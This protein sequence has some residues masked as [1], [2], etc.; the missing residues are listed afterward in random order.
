MT[1][2]L[3]PYLSFK[4][5]ARD[6]MSFYADV[7]GGE[8]T[9]STFGE[10]QASQDPAEHNL[11]MHSQLEAPNGMTLMA[12]DTPSSMEHQ[13]G[14]SISISLSGDDEAELRGYFERLSDGAEVFMPLDK[15]PWG[16]FFGMLTDRF[17]VRWMVNIAGGAGG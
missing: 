14:S 6:A 3:N 13:P 7:F 15:A 5:S 9:I 11:V 12:S 16:D 10:M 17:G 8:L 1:V 2:R 4:D